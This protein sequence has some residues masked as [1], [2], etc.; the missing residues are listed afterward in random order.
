M[1][2]LDRYGIPDKFTDL[3]G[4]EWEILDARMPGYADNYKFYRVIIHKDENG[5]E[6]QAIRTEDFIRQTLIEVAKHG[7]RHKIS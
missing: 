3:M 5:K 2:E 6:E 1:T 4:K 7:K